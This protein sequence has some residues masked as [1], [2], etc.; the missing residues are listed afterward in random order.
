MASIFESE[1]HYTIRMMKG[2]TVNH[3]TLTEVVNE[4]NK[5]D[6]IR[7][8]TDVFYDAIKLAKSMKMIRFDVS[9]LTNTLVNS[10]KRYPSSINK[11]DIIDIVKA[12]NTYIEYAIGCH[13]S[14]REDEILDNLTPINLF[15]EDDFSD[16]KDRFNFF[17]GKK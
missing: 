15:G 13:M 10:M 5:V 17:S 16:V 3:F 14:E 2:S 8:M 1:K 4:K 9:N 11:N 7:Y 6:V 12:V